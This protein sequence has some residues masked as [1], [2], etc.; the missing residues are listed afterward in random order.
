MNSPPPD[1]RVSHLRAVVD[2]V[3]Y[4]AAICVRREMVTAKDKDSAP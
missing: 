3:R 2:S 4:S 1:E